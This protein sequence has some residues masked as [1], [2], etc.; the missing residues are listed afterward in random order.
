[1]RTHAYPHHHRSSRR[2]SAVHCCW[3]EENEMT[4]GV[5]SPEPA[6]HRQQGWYPDPGNAEQVRWWSGS[7][8]SDAVQPHTGAGPTHDQ[9]SSLGRRLRWPLVGLAA[10][11]AVAG[12]VV[13]V[14]TMVGEDSVAVHYSIVVDKSCDDFSTGY[15]DISTGT[16][17]EVVDGAGRLLGFGDLGLGIDVGYECQYTADFE[18]TRS[19]DSIYRVT[20]GNENRGYLNFSD[21]DVIDGT[22][23]VSAV[24]G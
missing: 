9:Q 13:A 20:S 23:S 19:G 10:A 21:D 16:S 5:H 12:A 1:M 17:V 4:T 6:A 18:V 14:W 7:D 3:N 22:L 11:A 15:D 2:G 24:L 8:W